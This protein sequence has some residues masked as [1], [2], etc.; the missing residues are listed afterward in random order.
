MIVIFF[1]AQELEG[2]IYIIVLTAGGDREKNK[3]K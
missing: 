1:L 2:N 3:K